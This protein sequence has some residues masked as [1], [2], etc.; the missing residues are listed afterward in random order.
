MD[1]IIVKTPA[2]SANMGSG[3]DICGIALEKPYDLITIKKSPKPVIKNTGPYTALDDPEKVFFLRLLPESG[4]TTD[5]KKIFTLP[6]K[7]IFPTKGDWAQVRQ[8]Q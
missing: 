8:N 5:L 4:R 3:F 1:E 6:Y 2:T 7:N